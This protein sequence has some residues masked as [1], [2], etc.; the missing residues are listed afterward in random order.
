MTCKAKRYIY[1]Y[2]YIRIDHTQNVDLDSFADLSC[3]QKFRRRKT[4]TK[5]L[6]PHLRWIRNNLFQKLKKTH[7]NCQFP[8]NGKFCKCSSGSTLF[9]TEQWGKYDP[10]QPSNGWGVGSW[11]R[12]ENLHARSIQGSQKSMGRENDSWAGKNS[13]S[14]KSEVKNP[15]HPPWFEACAHINYLCC[16]AKL[17]WEFVFDT[18]KPP[19]PKTWSLSCLCETKRAFPFQV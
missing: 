10:A 17:F 3:L 1:T 8:S 12:L 5:K 2:I 16:S 7:V 11:N 14:L 4:F 15:P 13:H 6:L 9:H 18:S 19:K